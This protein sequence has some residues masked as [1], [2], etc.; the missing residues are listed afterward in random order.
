LPATGLRCGSNGRV[1]DLQAQTP[2][3][4]LKKT[5]QKYCQPGLGALT[6]AWNPS[7]SGGGDKEDCSLR[8]V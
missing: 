8:P 7:Y 1:P 6:H 3:F 4:K 5:K 2:K